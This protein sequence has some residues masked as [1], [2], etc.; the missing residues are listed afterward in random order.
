MEPHLQVLIHI[1]KRRRK[2]LG[3]EEIR[4]TGEIRG[5]GIR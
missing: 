2:T 1:L 3:K 4:E 5:E